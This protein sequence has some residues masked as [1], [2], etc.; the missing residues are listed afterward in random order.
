MKSICGAISGFS[1]FPTA[2]LAFLPLCFNEN[3]RFSTDRDKVTQE[4]YK[5]IIVVL[6]GD[7][8]TGLRLT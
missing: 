7:Q 3:S 1:R 8:I 4:F 5:E 2:D 6:T